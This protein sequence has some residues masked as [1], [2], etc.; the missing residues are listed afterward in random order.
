MKEFTGHRSDAVDT[1]QITSHQQR[2]S[3]S[4]I[5]QGQNDHK[6]E[7]SCE[8]VSK[9]VTKTVNL[10]EQDKSCNCN[11]RQMTGENVAQI[12][13]ELMKATSKKVKLLLGSR[14]KSIMIEYLC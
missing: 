14:W 2:K 6:S 12:V 11:C 13:S 4:A 10:S 8:K 7:G 1:Y 3:L 5:V 9:N